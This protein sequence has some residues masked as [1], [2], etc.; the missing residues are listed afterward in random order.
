MSTK[1]EQVLA[2]KGSTVWSVD[3]DASVQEAVT[4]LGTREIGAVL[5]CDAHGLV[6][7]FSER[8]CVRKILWQGRSTLESRVRDVMVANVISVTP[9]DSIQHCMALMT[10]RRVRHLPV[11][12]H[13]KV[14]GVISIGDVVHAML[15]EK[16]SLIESLEG[17]ISG[18]PSVRPAAH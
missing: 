6:G 3:P 5:V 13:G 17:Y 8:D 18:S 11:L 4:L 15:N 12:D 1:V 16:E 10:D 9:Q 2:Q 7:I 14:L